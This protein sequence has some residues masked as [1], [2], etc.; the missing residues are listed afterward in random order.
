MQFFAKKELAPTSA[1]SFQVSS[2]GW[3]DLN[4]V[5]SCAGCPKSLTEANPALLNVCHEPQNSDLVEKTVGSGAQRLC[6][7]SLG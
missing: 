4:K 6:T 1:Y 5:G 2:E 7:A 3:V